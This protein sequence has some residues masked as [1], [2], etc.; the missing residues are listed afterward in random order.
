[1]APFCRLIL[2]ILTESEVSIV[3]MKHCRCALMCAVM[4]RSH[5]IIVYTQT[6]LRK[7]RVSFQKM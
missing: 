2:V 6:I 1:M 5:G 4:A 3:N 7:T